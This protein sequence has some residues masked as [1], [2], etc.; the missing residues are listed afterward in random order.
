MIFSLLEAYP[1]AACAKDARGNLPLHY[2]IAKRSSDA[3][4]TALLFGLPVSRHES[5]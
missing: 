3:V 2:A 4:A 5:F 1:E